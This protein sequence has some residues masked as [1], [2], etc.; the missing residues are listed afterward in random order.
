MPKTSANSNT[1]TC[2]GIINVNGKFSA[3]GHQKIETFYLRQKLS[4][5]NLQFS[6]SY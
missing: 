5:D 1:K 3:S 6:K 2:N 4:F